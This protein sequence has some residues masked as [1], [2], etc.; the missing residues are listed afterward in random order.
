M[1]PWIGYL[2]AILFIITWWSCAFFPRSQQQPLLS[3][4]QAIPIQ[5]QMGFTGLSPINRNDII[6]AL[7]G[8]LTSIYKFLI[9]WD[10][11][12]QLLQSHSAFN[13][14]RIDHDK[15]L[16]CCKLALELNQATPSQI[17]S[18]RKNYRAISV[19]DDTT[20]QFSLHKPYSKI[21]PQSYNAACILL[22]LNCSDKIVAYP[23]GFEEWQPYFEHTALNN[24]GQLHAENLATVKPEVAFV[25]DYSNPST[26]EALKQQGIDIFTL[27]KLN[28][29][30]EICNAI[31]RVGH[32]V[33]RAPEAF[34]L[35]TFVEASFMHLDNCVAAMKISHEEP[36]HPLILY[37]FGQWFYPTDKNLTH[38]LLKRM[39]WG[40]SPHKLF[41]APFPH[42]WLQPMGLEQLVSS[43]PSHLIIACSNTYPTLKS[44]TLSTIPTQYIDAQVQQ[45]MSQHVVLAY[46]DILQSFLSLLNRCDN[47][48]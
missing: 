23:S 47:P 10:I 36:K 25:A 28:S 33:D 27:S 14:K 2:L 18:L 3:Q 45:S 32:I 17:Q 6:A 26:I 13:V 38:Q 21:L 29:P 42:Q 9:Q 16:L 15:L 19:A 1:K 12:A 35:S 39:E 22:A 24:T 48:L 5:E 37:Y 34:V 40:S 7:S 20:T 30:E 31:Q 8:D 41:D 46:F 43:K 11:D 44:D 4:F